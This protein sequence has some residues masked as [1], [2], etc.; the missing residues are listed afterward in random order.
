MKLALSPV[1]DKGLDHKDNGSSCTPT[2]MAASVPGLTLQMRAG[3]TLESENDVCR[4]RLHSGPA[5][6][7]G[8]AEHYQGWQVS[9]GSKK[10]LHLACLLEVL[11]LGLSP[12]SLAGKSRRAGVVELRA[13][14]NGRMSNEGSPL[15]LCLT[16][17]FSL[18]SDDRKSLTSHPQGGKCIF[19]CSVEN[20]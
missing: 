7:A 9:N 1:R 3:G 6:S 2:A 12:W 17:A 18:P 15:S 5:A 19:V 13:S 11:I 8:K 14:S 20:P 4:A 10:A 16:S